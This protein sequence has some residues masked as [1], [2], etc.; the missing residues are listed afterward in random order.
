MCGSTTAEILLPVLVMLIMVG[1][2]AAVSKTANGLDLHTDSST[3]SPSELAAIRA[4]PALAAN[5]SFA[6]DGLSSDTGLPFDGPTVAAQIQASSARSNKGT[7]GVQSIQFVGDTSP[8][9]LVDEIMADFKIAYP[10]FANQTFHR[11]ANDDELDSYAKGSDYATSSVNSAVFVAVSFLSLGTGNAWSYAI[12]GNA[13]FDFSSSS[14]LDTNVGAV[15]KLQ[16]TYKPE[17]FFVLFLRGHLLMQD[18]VENWIIGHELRASN[19]GVRPSIQRNYVYQPFPT[20]PYIQDDFAGTISSVLGLFFT[21]IY[22]WPVTRLVKGIVEE[23]QLR[24]KEGMRMMGLPDSALFCS[25][26]ATYTLMFLLTAIGITIVTS[27]SVYEHS[28][29]LYIFLFFFLF[30]MSTFAF[31]WLLSV[32]FSRSQV[33]TTF[34]A[35]LF[36][37]LFFPYFAVQSESTSRAAK[38]LACLSAQVCFGLGA[39]VIQKLESEANGINKAT[40]GISVDNWSYNA[41]IGMFCADFVIYLLLALYFQQVVP[42]EWGTHQKWWFCVQPRWWCPK[43]IVVPPAHRS[44]V[45]ATLGESGHVASVP[46]HQVLHNEHEGLV[47]H[48]SSSNSRA[49]FMEPVSEAL[50][51]ELGVSIRGLR[52]VF[53]TDGDPQ[54]FVAVKDMNLDLYSG[55][56]LALLGHNG[57]ANT[58][59]PHTPVANPAYCKRAREEE[60]E[61]SSSLNGLCLICGQCLRVCFLFAEPA[62]RRRST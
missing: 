9:N 29:K 34:A 35:L 41:T 37:A 2:R 27:R 42:S 23:K 1:L 31:C 25:W 51:S 19:G 43:G 54:D 45:A 28:N 22:M 38:T 6:F 48:S 47:G 30:A 61:L 53:P 12:R 52:K 14:T 21:I 58:P 17:P 16:T 7:A 46:L 36:L 56:I 50:R 5:H 3:L 59:R 57:S 33:A 15:D 13:T 55:Q 39:V 62:R 40:A 26:L 24:I 44:A 11:F 20:P 60:R 49:S 4:N 10:T 32:F 8:G 18:F